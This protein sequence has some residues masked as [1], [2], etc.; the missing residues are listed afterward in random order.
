VEAFNIL[1]FFVPALRDE[2]LDTKKNEKRS[3]QKNAPNAPTKRTPTFLPGQRTGCS[4][5]KLI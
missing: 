1:F 4:S 5:F 2:T 3:R